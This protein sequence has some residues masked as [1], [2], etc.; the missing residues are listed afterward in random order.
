MSSWCLQIN[1]KNQQIFCKD[2][3]P[4][5]YKRGQMKIRA[6][7]SN[8]RMISFWFSYTIFWLTFFWEAREEIFTN[9][10]LFF[11]GQFIFTKWQNIDFWSWFFF[12]KL[13]SGITQLPENS[14][15]FFF[16]QHVCFCLYVTVVCR[17]VRRLLISVHKRPWEK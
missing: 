6:H 15:D 2:F 16:C 8:N 7:C 9:I 13:F 17:I 5:L 11:F 12:I 3:C 4:N 10:S 14:Q 1:Q